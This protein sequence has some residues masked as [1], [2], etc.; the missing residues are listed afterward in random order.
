MNPGYVHVNANCTL[1]QAVP[2]KALTN[3]ISPGTLGREAFSPQVQTCF[4]DQ[5]D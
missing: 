1:G 2:Y 4:E 3:N 5:L